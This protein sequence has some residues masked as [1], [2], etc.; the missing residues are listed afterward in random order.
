MDESDLHVP[1]RGVENILV[2]KSVIAMC[3]NIVRV[4]FFFLL[5]LM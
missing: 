2:T 5:L 1:D 4:T 3:R